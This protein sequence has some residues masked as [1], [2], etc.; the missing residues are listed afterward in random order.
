M[1]KLYFPS[2]ICINCSPVDLVLPTGPDRSQAINLVKEDDGWTHL[3][4]LW[5]N[6]MRHTFTELFTKPLSIHITIFITKSFSKKGVLG[7]KQTLAY[8]CFCHTHNNQIAY[9]RDGYKNTRIDFIMCIHKSRDPPR[10]SLVL[11]HSIH[12]VHPPGQRAGGAA[13][14]TPPPIC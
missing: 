11:G 12:C 8:V 14:Q 4:R 2:S 9:Q 3:V 10:L 13:A 6:S 7:K 1:K 5:T